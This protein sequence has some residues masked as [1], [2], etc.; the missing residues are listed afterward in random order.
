MNLIRW[1]PFG[2]AISLRQAMDKLYADSF[3]RP[4]W[5]LSGNGGG[6][7]PAVDMYETDKEVVVKAVM[8]GVDAEGL[9]IHID[10]DNLTIK[11]ETKTE[12]ETSQENYFNRECRQGKFARSLTLPTNLKTDKAEAS[13]ENGMLTLTIPRAES[14]KPKVIKVKGQNKAKPIAGSKKE[15]TKE[16]KS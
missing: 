16:A 11:G 8:P 4:H 12:K 3:I 5:L 14:I 7:I 13:L 9:D 10:G 6:A 2:E 15:I 1:D